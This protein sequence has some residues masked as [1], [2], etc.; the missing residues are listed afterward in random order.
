MTS[1]RCLRLFILTTLL[2]LS[3]APKRVDAG[4][5]ANAILVLHATGPTIKNVCNSSITRPGCANLVYNNLALYPSLYYVHLLVKQ[6]NVAAGVGGLQCGIQYDAAPQSGLDV[7]GW[8]LCATLEFVSTG[9]PAAGG[10]NLI[11][12]DTTTKCQRFVPS[13]DDPQNGVTALAGYFYVGAYT[14]DIMRLVPRPVDGQAKVADCT[15]NEDLIAGVGFPGPISHLGAISFGGPG[16]SPSI[17][18]GD[19]VEAS[20]WGAIK[21]QIRR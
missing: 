9:W 17:C 2:A 10:G 7:F 21:A 14:P 1:R 18:G 3:S 8:S 19:P 15:A 12:W 13:G 20:T 11:T 16:G 4:P 6:G 5:N